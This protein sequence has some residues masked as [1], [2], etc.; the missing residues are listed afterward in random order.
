METFS[1]F[2]VKVFVGM[3]T[4]KLN[5]DRVVAE[6]PGSEDGPL[7]VVLGALHG[8]EKAGVKALQYLQKMLEVEHITN[9]DFSFKGNLVG[10]IGNQKAYNL[11][12]R[13]ID[14]DIN[15]H[16][17]PIYISEIRSKPFNSLKAEDLEILQVLKV[18][19]EAIHAYEP[20][21]LYVLDLHTT[22]SDGGIFTIP[23]KEKE[24]QEIAEAMYA[25]VIK[26]M[27]DNIKG[28]TLHY[29]N[30]AN[31]TIPTTAITFESG[32]HDDP[33]SIN[34]AIAAAINFLRT[35]GCVES[36]DVEN[37]HDKVLEEFVED[38]PRLTKLVLR[39][40]VSDD[41]NFKMLPGFK[42]FQKVSKDDLLATDKNGNIYA[43]EDGRLLMP[44]YQKK[45]EDGFFLVREEE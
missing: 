33:K 12:E 27:I 22:S 2:C 20:Q 17:D 21:K 42:N 39:H 6:F 26:G 19:D 13:F 24:S 35:I 25:T 3:E 16:W 4:R 18:I 1:I 31:F 43:P 10:I 34:R 28:T 32:Q 14:I 44:L 41:D 40:S 15:R 11:G 7:V 36:Q 38:L 5:Y 23:S 8:N 45:G 37:I 30:D 29:F 9:P